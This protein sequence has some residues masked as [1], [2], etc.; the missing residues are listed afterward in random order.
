MLKIRTDKHKII[1]KYPSIT[2][3]HVPALSMLQ[4]HK[5]CAAGLYWRQS[6]MT[7]V[8]EMARDPAEDCVEQD[9]VVDETT[10]L[11]PTTISTSVA[12][13]S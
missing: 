2:P 4:H 8:T 6:W 7:C 5:H 9:A 11:E 10:T 13:H 1:G 12:P 3:S